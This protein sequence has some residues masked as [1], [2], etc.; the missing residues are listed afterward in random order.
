MNGT[1]CTTTPV[2]VK[3]E[4]Q[5]WSIKHLIFNQLTWCS[6]WTW[7]KAGVMTMGD[8][9]VLTWTWMMGMVALMHTMDLKSH[10]D[11]CRS[12]LALCRWTRMMTKRWGEED[13]D[14]PMKS[15]H[16]EDEEEE[17][18]VR[19]K[20]KRWSYQK[21]LN[22]YLRQRHG[23]SRGKKENKCQFFIC[24]IKPANQVFAS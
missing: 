10:F 11:E 9:K 15:K 5:S 1:W 7:F 8:R 2:S 22:L 17:P 24:D 21:K 4:L 6:T 13:E 3:G 16:D 18:E 12:R 19:P 20:G 14:R 23:V